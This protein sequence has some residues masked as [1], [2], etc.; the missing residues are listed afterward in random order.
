MAKSNNKE[1]ERNIEELNYK[2]RRLSDEPHIKTGKEDSPDVDAAQATQDDD[3]DKMLNI[4][5]KM[6]HELHIYGKKHKT[7]LIEVQNPDE[8]NKLLIKMRK[9]EV[10]SKPGKA[11]KPVLAKKDVH[12]K[13]TQD[14]IASTRNAN[15]D[16]SNMLEGRLNY[17]NSLNQPQSQQIPPTSDPR[18]FLREKNEPNSQLPY[19]ISKYIFKNKTSRKWNLNEVLTNRFEVVS[20]PP[21][22]KKESPKSAPVVANVVQPKEAIMAANTNVNEA[23]NYSTMYNMGTPVGG[24]QPNVQTSK[25]PFVGQRVANVNY[26]QSSNIAPPQFT[27]QPQTLQNSTGS[28]QLPGLRNILNINEVTRNFHSLITY[29]SLSLFEFVISLTIYFHILRYI[30]CYSA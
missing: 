9:N 4:F 23:R 12:Q 29:I 30:F 1:M 17:N 26:A 2:I 20:K 14:G 13:I 7:N 5:A 10:G 28:Y 27:N 18:M 25:V 6:I 19:I 3:C 16:V 8:E 22:P 11:K 24:H 21:T 15:D